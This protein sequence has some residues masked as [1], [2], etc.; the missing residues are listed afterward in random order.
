MDQRA[1]DLYEQHERAVRGYL[2]RLTR[3]ADVTDDLV[4]D[5]F[6]RAVRGL[7]GFEATGR[8]RAWL[9]RI[10]RNRW[11]DWRRTNQRR[12]EA[13]IAG[14][15]AELPVGGAHDA[16]LELRDAL[17]RVDQA[18]AELFLLREVS[19]LSYE[20]MA[21]TCGLTVPAVRS[22]LFRVRLAVRDLLRPM[23]RST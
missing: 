22:R 12:P 3:R 10:A 13:E 6:V 7:D 1:R 4:Q 20:E 14:G 15:A 21:E 11:L 8:D 19:G 2:L 16:A 9:F 23:E 5:V 18:D 17:S